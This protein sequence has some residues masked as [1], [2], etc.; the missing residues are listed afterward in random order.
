MLQEDR[1]HCELKA[2]KIEY[3][4]GGKGTSAHTSS[5]KHRAILSNELHMFNLPPLASLPKNHGIF[6]T[7]TSVAGAIFFAPNCPT[8][9]C[10]H[11]SFASGCP[12][13][14]SL[15]PCLNDLHD[16]I[17]AL[18]YV[19]KGVHGFEKQVHFLGLQDTYRT[20]SWG[21]ERATIVMIA[22]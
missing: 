15:N 7:C 21:L 4:L 16:K 5:R 3:L 22:Y 2:S 12:K 1:R 18:A 13:C 20:R 9:G 6:E 11:I 19:C 17:R 8:I 10:D 14:D